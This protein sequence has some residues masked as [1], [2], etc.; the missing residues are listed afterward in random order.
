[1][2]TIMV[3]G[4]TGFTGTLVAQEVNRVGLPLAVSARN[5]EKLA[6]LLKILPD[7]TVH[8]LA[9][10]ADPQSLDGLFEGSDVVINTIGPFTDL[11]LPMVKAAV[12]QGVH[13][14][15][16]TGEASYMDAVLETYDQQA[17]E[18]SIAIICAQAF[19]Y[20]LGDCACSLA[21]NAL[22]GSADSLEVFYQ[23]D[24]VPT[25]RGTLKSILRMAHQPVQYWAEGRLHQEPIGRAVETIRFP[26]KD[27]NFTALG[28]TGGEIIHVPRRAEVGL[29]R[30][31]MVVP[32]ASV[33]RI[34]LGRPAIGLLRWSAFQ[35]ATD[36][37]ID[38]RP[39]GPNSEQRSTNKF[40]ILVRGQRGNRRAEC[41][42]TGH[43]PYGITATI[44]V[45]GA[46]M[47][48]EQGTRRTGV[49]STAMAFDPEEFLRQLESA[50]VRTEVQT[51][52]L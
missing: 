2:A 52:S 36:A 35:R 4:A 17:R 45:Q 15:D 29:L 27:T 20:A 43:D 24:S 32:R 44:A 33:R 3:A 42:V 50:Q 22:G 23:V 49:V 14:V 12:E 11:G 40:R 37:W 46:R 7:S 26:R 31:Y 48:R 5:S 41:L 18:K 28:F 16:T 10:P 1:M 39:E 30:T 8:R 9:S 19:E 21:L 34:R 38:K 13:Y 47:L 51:T 6:W 25:S